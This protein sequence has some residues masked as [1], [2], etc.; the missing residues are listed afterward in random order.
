MK[1]VFLKDLQNLTEGQEVNLC[2]WVAHRRDH[3]GLVFLDLV[4]STG[5]STAVAELSRLD[6][7]TKDAVAKARPED[8][9]E[10]AGMVSF[11]RQTRPEIEIRQLRLVAQTNASSQL[12]PRSASRARSEKEI[13][14]SLRNRHLY[15]RNP[16]SIAILR[17]KSSL[18]RAFRRYL[19]D[20]QFVEVDTPVLTQT[21]LYGPDEAF[22][23]DYFGES[24]YLSQ[25]AGLYLGAL[26]QALEKV[27]TI[28]PSF[29]NAPSRSPRH[30]PEFWHVKG[31]M[32]FSRRCDMMQLV[33]G[34]IHDVI[35]WTFEDCPDEFRHLG[36][37]PDLASIEPP[38]PK[39]T[40]HEAVELVRKTRPDAEFVGNFSPR[41]EQ[42]LS[43]Y[44]D[45]PFFITDL[46][47]AT[48]PFAYKGNGHGG[49][50]TADLIANHGF[51]ELLGVAEFETDIDKLERHLA[52]LP[53][54]VR[55]GAR[56]YLELIEHAAVPF[57][58]FGLG[59]ERVLRWLL[60][61]RHVRETFAFPRLYGRQPYP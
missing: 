44:F 52:E 32:A 21:N 22:R 41:Q 29:R 31:Q 42:L 59:I 34:M 54:E 17:I 45:K 27:Y 19:E 10:L 15:I 47:R 61:L 50:R 11:R 13:D 37:S 2:C 36:C 6:S 18:K 8:A 9:V 12:K 51:G 3:G 55:Q 28:A 14:N 40:W 24:V 4:D 39:I 25:C 48:E 49:T 35:G 5:A 1:A 46:P 20:Q 16:D 26:T 7:E 23:L 57:T 43:T 60:G 33:S 58:G 56:W 38:Y 30:N 53:A